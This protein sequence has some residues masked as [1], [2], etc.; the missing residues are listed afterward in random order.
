MA[1]APDE[2]CYLAPP[3]ARAAQRRNAADVLGSGWWPA[4]L[5]AAEVTGTSKRQP[6][7]RVLNCQAQ[8]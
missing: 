8:R 4:I 6:E 3:A 7:Y 1:L 5:L 2:G